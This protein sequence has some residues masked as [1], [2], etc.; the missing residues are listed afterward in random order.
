MNN[1]LTT[2][3]QKLSH[4]AQ[5]FLNTN[6]SGRRTFN[7]LLT[8]GDDKRP[9]TE[10]DEGSKW[11]LSQSGDEHAFV[12]GISMNYTYMGDPYQ[13]RM[14]DTVLCTE[15]H[16]DGERWR[17][18]KLY[19]SAAIFNKVSDALYEKATSEE[20]WVRLDDSEAFSGI[21]SC[22]PSHGRYQIWW[23]D[24]LPRIDIKL[25]SDDLAVLPHV[26]LSLREAVPNYDWDDPSEYHTR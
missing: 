6:T 14:H 20:A 1:Q 21:L 5:T 7:A 26:L 19:T 16:P 2:I 10:L 13:C 25:L 15:A 8:L 3:Q 23:N 17:H 11:S 9:V 18:I 22:F 12:Y 24:D 4:I